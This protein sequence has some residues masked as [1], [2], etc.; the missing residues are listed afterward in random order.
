MQLGSGRRPKDQKRIPLSMRIAPETRK[1]L[2]A[3]AEANGRSITQ[4]AELRLEQSF[5]EEKRFSEIMSRIYGRQL[6][7]FMM[8]IGEV[9]RDAGRSMGFQ[10]TFTLGGADDWM[11]LPYPFDQA[12]KSISLMIEA[13]RPEGV[14]DPPKYLT[15]LPDGLLELTEA[16]KQMGPGFAR[17]YLDAVADPSSAITNHA[18]EAGI[19]IRD[20]LG[21]AADRIAKNLERLNKAAGVPR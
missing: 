1:R 3:R 5:Q 19:E 8:L 21:P 18:A 16:A 13:I 6:A 2:E 17:P 20:L 11:E 14:P 4:E 15:S 10:S 9:L 7:G 12:D